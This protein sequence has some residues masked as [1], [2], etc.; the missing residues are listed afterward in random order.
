MAANSLGGFDVLGA[1]KELT[2]KEFQDICTEKIFK[3]FQMWRC[4]PKWP[5][6]ELRSQWFW[7]E[8]IIINIFLWFYEY[9]FFSKIN[10]KIATLVVVLIEILYLVNLINLIVNLIKNSNLN[11]KI[12]CVDIDSFFIKKTL[13]DFSLC[14]P[15]RSPA[16]VPQA[17]PS[18]QDCCGWAAQSGPWGLELAQALPTSRS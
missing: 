14:L 16:P 7:V 5:S 8:D 17:P 2:G 11:S 6:Q 9:L 3:L 13:E 10:I 4:L 1:K 18:A 15:A 12:L